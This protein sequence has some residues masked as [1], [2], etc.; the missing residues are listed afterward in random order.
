MKLS[1]ALV[2][3]F[4][5][6]TT[7][8]CDR[9]TKH[10][11]AETLAGTAGHSFLADTIRLQYAENSGGFLGFG[12]HWPRPLRTAFFTV[13]NA[14]LLAALTIAAVRLRWRGPALFGLALCVAGGLSNLL[15]R[16]AYGQVIDFLN[17]GFGPLRTGI[18]N[19]A[20]VAIMLGAC[21]VAITI[22][23]DDQI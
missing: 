17:V 3:L 13:G 23:R 6:V 15:D 22:A 10:V 8:G 5:A 16:I 2:L 18:F 9:V 1:L 7:I 21:L 11:A 12:A 14:V 19:V 20:D 4:A